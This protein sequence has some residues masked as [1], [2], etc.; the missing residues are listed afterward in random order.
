MD[1]AMTCG[2]K[3]GTDWLEQAEKDVVRG[4]EFWEMIWDILEWNLQA[5]Q[6]YFMA[7]MGSAV[8]RA[9]VFKEVGERT[10]ISN[11]SYSDLL[12]ERVRKEECLEETKGYFVIEFLQ[13]SFS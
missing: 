5:E 9:S 8:K 7:F 1:E 3:T 2:I 4:G 6:L 11:H 13:E 12:L 10:W